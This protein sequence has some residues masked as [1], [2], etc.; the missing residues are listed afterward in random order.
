[1]KQEPAAGHVRALGSRPVAFAA[2][3]ALSVLSGCAGLDVEDESLAEI[4]HV[5][6]PSTA[7]ETGVEQTQARVYE[8][9][10]YYP[11]KVVVRRQQ[12]RT[13]RIAAWS[14]D[15][16]FLGDKSVVPPY[17]NTEWKKLSL[18]M[19]YSGVHLG[20]ESIDGNVYVLAPDDSRRFLATVGVGVTSISRERFIW[21]FREFWEDIA[22]HSGDRGIRLGVDLH[23]FGFT[24]TS[25]RVVLMVRDENRQEF[26]SSL[27]GPI[28][29]DA[30][31][32]SAPAESRQLTWNLQLDLPYDQIRQLGEGRVITV[33]P[34][35]RMESGQVYTGNLHIEFLVGGPPER[36]AGKM[37][38][39]VERVD[40]RIRTLQKELEILQ[41]P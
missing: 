39:E 38:Q 14:N 5:L 11:F 29:V 12:G 25:H 37:R 13:V 8:D 35:V 16:R 36:I 27:G 6:A 7:L 2:V 41:R 15:N 17:E 21:T 34:S 30:N 22:L 33:T 23:R 3:F 31:R 19:P 20:G 10:L 40:S 4:S 24:D 28:R 18:F 1:M 32:L 9:G 26:P